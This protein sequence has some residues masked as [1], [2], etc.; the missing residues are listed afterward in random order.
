MSAYNMYYYYANG[1]KVQHR[2]NWL[3]TFNDLHLQITS[4]KYDRAGK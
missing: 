2:L 1:A 3:T 4:I